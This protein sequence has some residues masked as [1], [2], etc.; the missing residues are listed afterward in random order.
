MHYFLDTEFNGHGGELISLVLV[1]G[2][3]GRELYLYTPMKRTPHVWV[4]EN[5]I[6][7]IECVGA[8]PTVIDPWQ[9]G[10][11]IAGF[12]RL[13]PT[14]VIITDWPDDISYFCK[15]L[16]TGPGQMVTISNL[17]FQMF[18]VDSYPTTLPGAVQHNA[19][20]D[21]RALRHKLENGTN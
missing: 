4:K 3:G 14:P 2:N 18:R 19:L 15:C 7:I 21:A 11:L 5:V 8:K 6:P 1:E 12:L 9:F 20:W 13:D 10:H 17:I 16:I